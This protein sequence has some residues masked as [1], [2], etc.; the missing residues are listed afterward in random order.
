MLVAY[1]QATP[2]FDDAVAILP[3][4]GTRTNTWLGYY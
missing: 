1:A 3:H 2:A 4:L